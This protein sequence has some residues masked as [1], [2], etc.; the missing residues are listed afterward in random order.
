MEKEGFGGE[1]HD[2]ELILKVLNF[3]AISLL[4]LTEDVHKDIKPYRK[5]FKSY[6]MTMPWDVSDVCDKEITLE[7]IKHI[8]GVR[9]LSQ[10]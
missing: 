4:Y 7:A 1:I 6:G 10:K 5:F 3:S 9:F 2:K 8:N